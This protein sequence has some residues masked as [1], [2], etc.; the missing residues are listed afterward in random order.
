MMEK[1]VLPLF[2]LFLIVILTG[3]GTG[4]N[5]ESLSSSQEVSEKE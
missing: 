1:I 3:C 2:S 4:K 5:Y